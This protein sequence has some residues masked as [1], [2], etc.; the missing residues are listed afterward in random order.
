MVNGFA[1]ELC[2]AMLAVFIRGERK[3]ARRQKG[4]IVKHTCGYNLCMKANF[5]NSKRYSRSII[6]DS[7]DEISDNTVV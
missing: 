2:L 4:A 6:A 7:Y 1:I 3:R 5:F